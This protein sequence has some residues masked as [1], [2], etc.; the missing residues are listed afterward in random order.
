MAGG[1]ISLKIDKQDTEAL[2][3]LVLTISKS[4]ADMAD[5]LHKYHAEAHDYS[6]HEKIEKENS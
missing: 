2:E 1:T 6:G 5:A 4:F 3:R